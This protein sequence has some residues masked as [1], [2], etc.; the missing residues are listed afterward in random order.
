MSSGVHPLDDC[1]SIPAVVTTSISSVEVRKLRGDAS[2]AAF[3]KRLGVTPNTVY[4][5]ELPEGSSEARRPRGVEL[6]K[7]SR[8]LS[9]QVPSPLAQQSS[10]AALPSETSD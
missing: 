8:L 7:L 9:G 10:D 2:R 4:R 3:A 6:E 1:G 5:W